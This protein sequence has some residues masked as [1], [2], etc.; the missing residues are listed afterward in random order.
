[1]LGIEIRRQ[2]NG[3]VF[4]VQER[5]ARDVVKRF[6]MKGCKPVST[7]LELRS[8]LDSSQPP[9]SDEEKSEMVNIPYRSVIGSLR[10]LATCAR[11]D[12]AAAV[13]ELS[14]FNQNL[15]IVHWEGMKHVLR[16]LS[17]TVGEGLMYK[18]GAHVEVWGYSDSGH[19]EERET[20]RGRS[21]YV[22][23]S[24]GA[25]I[26]WRSSMM[27]LVTHSSCESEYVGLSEAGN[28]AV[29]LISFRVK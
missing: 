13:S 3:D 28:E 10:Y 16:Y 14:K 26:S 7:Q 5:Y 6:N 2:V 1:M 23:L 11:L 9:V 8:Q 29:Y 15:G 4:L 25:A 27:K 20:C 12:L 18:R 19:A 24:V 17:D 21:G 22:F